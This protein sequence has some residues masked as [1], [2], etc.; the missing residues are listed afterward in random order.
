MTLRALVFDFGVFAPIKIDYRKVFTVLGKY[1]DFQP[2]AMKPTDL[3]DSLNN[4]RTK[5]PKKAEEVSEK[6]SSIVDEAESDQI[7]QFQL[8]P[9]VKEGLASTKPMKLSLIATTELGSKSAG[10]FLK[11]RDIIG[12]FS[13]VVSRDN[14]PSA[15]DLETRLKPIMK[16]S[17]LNASE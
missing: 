7:G 15:R 3:F 6:I 17:E 1:P 11:E 9:G 10:K 12:F 5:S 2:V 14:L 16:K 4:L 13:E 8:Y